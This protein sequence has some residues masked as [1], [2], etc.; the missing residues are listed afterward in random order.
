MSE[1]EAEA[2]TGG[3]TTLSTVTSCLTTPSKIGQIVISF[4]SWVVFVLLVAITLNRDPLL[5]GKD[6][7]SW[8][9]C[10][11]LFRSATFDNANVIFL[12][13]QTKLP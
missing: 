13:L 8:P 6:Q 9:P 12:F 2:E 11:N 1:A 5:K 7:Y 10:P 3:T 4:N